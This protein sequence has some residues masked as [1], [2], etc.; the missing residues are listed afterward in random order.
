[1]R[2]QKMITCPC[3]VSKDIELPQVVD[4][5]IETHG[6]T[7]SKNAQCA[8]RDLVLPNSHGMPKMQELN[9]VLGETGHA[10]CNL[11]HGVG[12]LLVATYLLWFATLK[13][14][15]STVDV[16]LAVETRTIPFYQGDTLLGYSDALIEF[17]DA[18]DD[19]SDDDMLFDFCREYALAERKAGRNLDPSLL[20]KSVLK[21]MNDKTNHKSPDDDVTIVSLTR[22]RDVVV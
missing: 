13:P 19:M 9:V 21:Y 4:I 22:S 18:N 1:M 15:P 10:A 16:V 7:I 17:Y 2:N 8:V 5:V 20:T 14:T 3:C 6:S 12:D 11:R